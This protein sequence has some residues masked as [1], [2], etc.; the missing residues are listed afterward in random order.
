[1]K[2]TFFLLI[3][4]LFSYSQ[5]LIP[6]PSFETYKK[7]PCDL[8][9]GKIQELLED[10]SQPIL[11]STD[12]WNSSTD[13]DCYLN[14]S[15]INK[16]PRTG[17]GM[18]GMIPADIHLNFK[19]EYKEYIQVKLNEKLKKGNL[20]YGEFFVKN[21]SMNEPNIGVLNSNNLGMAFSDTLI[22]I[23]DDKN[24]PDHL[25]LN[26]ALNEE[27]IIKNDTT[28]HKIS[29]CFIAASDYNYLLLGNFFSIDSTKIEFVNENN[30]QNSY[31]Y[32]FIDDVALYELPYDIS[33]LSNKAI[34]CHHDQEVL[35]DA[36]VAGA[37][38]YTWSDGSKGSSIITHQRYDHLYFVDIIFEECTLRHHFEI[39]FVEQIFLPSDTLLC[40]G[41]ELILKPQHSKKE[42]IWNDGSIGE[43]KKI[44]KPG[45]Y[46][47]QV[48]SVCNVRD[49]IQ[50]E[51][52]ECPGFIPNV[53]T[54][55]QDSKND[56]FVIEN[57]Q[58]RKWSLTIY[59]RWGKLVY[60]N[61]HYDNSW[62][63]DNL[64]EGIYYYYIYSIDLNKSL[65]GWI[66]II[67]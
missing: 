64:P 40:N 12:Y 30:F 43:T 63:G 24:S 3:F 27:N 9:S 7:L 5:N 28:W 56:Y 57:I 4:P 23:L 20:Y 10:W 6:N 33:S 61:E 65:K 37:L 34:F 29:G 62:N 51:Y 19:T 44:E 11:T 21:R 2:H 53:I 59:N 32:Y 18:I 26:P 46:W 39:E 48:P 35:L 15:R 45:L 52:I 31:A 16:F 22:S 67:R 58:N 42:Y 13:E 36:E 25:K 50:V 54:P 8:V 1:M 38:D 47:V 14:P 17:M 41:E 60:S 66:H 49:S 55:N